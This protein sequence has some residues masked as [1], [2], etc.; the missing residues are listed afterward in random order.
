M[1]RLSFVAAVMPVDAKE[2]C[3][4]VR[5]GLLAASLDRPRA[6]VDARTSAAA[7]RA[8]AAVDVAVSRDE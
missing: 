5:F 1:C 8:L 3:A 2:F 6:N 7:A 4:S